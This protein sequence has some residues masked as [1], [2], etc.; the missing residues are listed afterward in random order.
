MEILF[1][2]RRLRGRIR[3][4][5]GSEA[6]LAR[7]LGL[8]R[9]AVSARLSNKTPFTRNEIVLS[10]EILEISS[11]DIGA[12]FFNIGTGIMRNSFKS[13]DDG[14]LLEHLESDF[15]GMAST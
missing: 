10:A 13:T 1:D 14:W 7:R 9:S 3:E 2:N 15:A 6:E 4:M 5:L 11:S 12:Y 8:P